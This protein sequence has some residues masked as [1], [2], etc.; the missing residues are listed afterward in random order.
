[1]AVAGFTFDAAI[2]G[3]KAK[4]LLPLHGLARAAGKARSRPG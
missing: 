2:T 3:I 1:V 4:G